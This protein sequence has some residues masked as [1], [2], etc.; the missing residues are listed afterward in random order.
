MNLPDGR[1]MKVRDDYSKGI[2]TGKDIF[3][4]LFS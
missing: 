3:K 2:K 1:V 4:A